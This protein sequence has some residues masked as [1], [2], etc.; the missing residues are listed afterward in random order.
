[1]EDIMRPTSKLVILLLVL[2]S[3]LT[4][5]LA[6]NPLAPRPTQPQSEVVDPFTGKF[7]SQDGTMLLELQGTNGQ[8]QGQL[9][10]EGSALPLTGVGS[11]S[12]LTGTL[13]TPE[14]EYIFTLQRS[15][16]GVVLAIDGETVALQRQNGMPTPAKLPQPQ[17]V[18]VPTPAGPVPTPSP[19]PTASSGIPQPPRDSWQGNYQFTVYSQTDPNQKQSALLTIQVT[20]QPDGT[21]QVVSTLDGKPL[22][23]IRVSA[24]GLDLSTGEEQ[25][26][27]PWNTAQ[28]SL[29]GIPAQTGVQNGLTVFSVQSGTSSTQ[30]TYDPSGVLVSYQG[31]ENGQCTQMQ[32]S[33]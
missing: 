24:Q 12:M 22:V 21:Y 28:T 33:R 26:P 23:D 8:Y 17:P 2:V 1:M 10:V 6:Q 13:S 15:D 16:T 31:C 32:L 25:Y 14:A 4:F 19:L 11:A 20:P 30:A 9:V 3:F 7:V 27:L 18:P 5:S 29:F